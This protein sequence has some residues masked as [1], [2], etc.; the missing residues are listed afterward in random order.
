MG[1]EGVNLGALSCLHSF[2]A[3]H[4]FIYEVNTYLSN[5]DSFARL[6]SRC[7]GFRCERLP[8]STQHS[9]RELLKLNR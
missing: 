3:T 6:C 9:S 8:S 1:Q 5:A 4:S 7:W 2:F